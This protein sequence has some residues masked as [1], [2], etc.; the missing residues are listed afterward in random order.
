M[1]APLRSACLLLPAAPT[2][3]AH[4]NC[5]PAASPAGTLQD[6]CF[7]HVQSA[8]RQGEEG[9]WGFNVS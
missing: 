6:L 8:G 7:A 2:Q 3:E 4:P 1:F 9:L 5:C